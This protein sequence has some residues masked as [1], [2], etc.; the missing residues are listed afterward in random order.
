M[1][2]PV[3]RYEVYICPICKK[4]YQRP[5]MDGSLGTVTMSCGVLHAPGSCCHYKEELIDE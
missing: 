1:N 3:I 4:K 5:T 2:S